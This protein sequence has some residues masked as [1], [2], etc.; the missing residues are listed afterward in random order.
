[1]ILDLWNSGSG[2]KA[3]A[4]RLNALGILS[5]KGKKWDHSSVTSVVK[6]YQ[7]RPEL[8]ALAQFP[9]RQTANQKPR[10]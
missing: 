1:L 7:S 2:P 6:A 5:K 4:D 8:S 10:A 9:V 3:I